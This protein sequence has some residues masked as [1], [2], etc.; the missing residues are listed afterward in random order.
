MRDLA[1]REQLLPV[2]EV[3]TVER[4]PPPLFAGEDADLFE[5]LGKILATLATRPRYLPEWPDGQRAVPNELLR[6][7]LFTC[8]NRNHPRRFMKDEEIAVIGDGQVIYRGEELR[9]DDE[10]VWM[11]LMHLS[12]KLPL[13]E[14]VEFTPYAFIKALG[15]PL[16]GQTYERLRTTLSRMQATAL[17]IQSK[18]LHCFISVSLIQKFISRNDRNENLAH[19]QVWVGRELR[20]LFDEEFLT[21]VVWET[22]RSLPDGIASKLFGY[23]ASHR[24]PFP[25][26][27]E[28][29][30]K[31]CGSEMSIKHFKAELKQAL[32]QLQE[33]G[34]LESWEVQEEL[35][36]V[37]RRY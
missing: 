32:D 29:L 15:W 16:K 8:R 2:P 5:P 33:I 36:L 27:I 13:G 24:K 14:C 25:V 6:S 11:H 37:T 9:Q 20:L 26:K 19:W 23:W 12:K 18:R 3:P 10:L 1:L 35:V 21:R 34:F 22:R 28:T 30:L 31:L 17:R 4:S 7:A